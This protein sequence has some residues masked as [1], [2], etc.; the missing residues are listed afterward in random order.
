MSNI[1]S[2]ENPEFLNNYL[3]HIKLVQLLSERTIQ[4]YFT[5]IRLFL[6]YIYENNH[7]TGKPIEEI[8]I[9]DMSEIEI[10]K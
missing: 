4:E 7:D 10:S 5:D 2:A 1:N 3:I 8:S 9:S 6:R